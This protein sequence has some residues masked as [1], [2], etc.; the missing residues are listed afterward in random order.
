MKYRR[1][2][3]TTRHELVIAKSRFIATAGCAKTVAEVR[4]FI[5]QMRQD[6]PQAHH[7]VYAFRVGF[8][9]SVTEGISDDGEPSGTAGPPTLAVLRGQPVGDI[10]LVT[11]RYF[12]GTKLGT[13]GLVR[14]YTE[15]AQHVIAKM[16]TEPA[17]QLALCTT[18][19][20]YALYQPIKDLLTEETNVLHEDFGEQVTLT[21]QLPD[22]QVDS[23]RAAIINRSNGRAT[24]HLVPSD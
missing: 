20:P 13:G 4:A 24:L 9:A 7:Y 8:G 11:A 6:L 21:L 3:E 18:T 12:G 15:A 14:A 23:L 1:P 19:L 5:A 10:V 22:D 2:A 17:Q 16:P